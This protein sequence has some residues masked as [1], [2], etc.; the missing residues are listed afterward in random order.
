MTTPYIV[1]YP[2][3]EYLSQVYFMSIFNAP[4]IAVLFVAVAGCA[5]H[6]GMQTYKS[7]S[8]EKLIFTGTSTLGQ[9]DINVNGTPV[10]Q[11]V[12]AYSSTKVKYK[13]HNIEAKCT[14]VVSSYGGPGNTECDM[15]VDQ[16]FA[17]NLYFR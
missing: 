3:S 2:P 12:N 8:G 14:I 13:G 11:S 6:A 10:I 15:Y 9:V 5:T 16:E 17:A 7:G 1:V 4:L